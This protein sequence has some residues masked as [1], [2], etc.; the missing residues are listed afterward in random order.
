MKK[1]LK[2]IRHSLKIYVLSLFILTNGFIFYQALLSGSDS[3]HISYGISEFISNV[4]RFLGAPEAKLV[5]PR[6]VEIVNRDTLPPREVLILGESYRLIGKISPEDTTDKSIIWTSE[7]NKVIDMK[8]NGIALATGIGTTTVKATSSNSLVYEELVLSVVDIPQVTDFDFTLD[9]EEVKVGLSQTTSINVIDINLPND[10]IKEKVLRGDILPKTDLISY[11]SLNPLIATINQYGIIRGVSPGIGEVVATS[12]SNTKTISINVIPNPDPIIQPLKF[13]LSGPSETYI[14]RSYPL[15][16]DFGNTPSD[17]GV[18]YYSNDSKIA[19]ITETGEVYGYKF[20]GEVKI[21]AIYNNDPDLKDEI[22]LNFVPVS[23]ES[24]SLS[25]PNSSNQEVIAGFTQFIQVSL[26]PFDTNDQ[27][28]IWTV[29]NPSLARVVSREGGGNLV[30]LKHGEVIITA[31]SVMDE[32]IYGTLSVTILPGTTLTPNE[33]ADMNGFIRKGLGHVGL[34]L[35]NGILGV[36]TLLLWLINKDK[37]AYLISIPLGLALSVL[38]ESLQL[39]APGRFFTPFDIAF[40]SLGYLLG[41]LIVYLI[42][43]SI[44]HF[45][46]KSL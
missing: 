25:M 27:Q 32:T 40:N 35:V 15:N 26:F 42:N 34:F 24:L 44:K 8:T 5:E 14:Y 10:E 39:L 6:T 16:I 23:P 4:L 33:M 2:H 30:G 12:G 11:T 46:R 17:L 22:I 13:E 21:T 18:S 45:K 20:E 37:L 43:L 9:I 29:S 41:I 28:V 3:G 36:Y 31:K 38:A 7:D 19:R 1:L